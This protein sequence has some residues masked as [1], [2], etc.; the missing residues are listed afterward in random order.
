[1]AVIAISFDIPL[2]VA[3]H[4]HPFSRLLKSSPLGR[5]AFLIIMT[6]VLNRH[7]GGCNIYSSLGFSDVTSTAKSHLR[8]ARASLSTFLSHFTHI[9]PQELYCI[10]LIAVVG[11]NDSDRREQIRV[12]KIQIPIWLI[13]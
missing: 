4:C 7:S 3:K 8:Q 1:M 5:E 10:T 13:S 12:Q 9:E 11:I 6:G 2:D